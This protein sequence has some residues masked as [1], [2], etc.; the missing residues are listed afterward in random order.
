M[1]D[2][3]HVWTDGLRLQK[4]SDKWQ[5]SCRIKSVKESIK[6]TAQHGKPL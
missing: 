1:K 3:P 6:E 2:D 4:R 5:Q